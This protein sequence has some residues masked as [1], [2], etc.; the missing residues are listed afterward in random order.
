M[1]SD[2]VYVIG[3]MSGTSL[4]GLDIVYVKFDEKDLRNFKILSTETISYSNSW[5]EKLQKAI[6][7]PVDQIEKLDIEYGAFLGMETQK[8]IEKNKINSIDF[9]ASHGHTIFHQPDKGITLQI[10]NGQ[11]ISDHTD[12]KVVC[13]FRA[14]DVQYGGQGAPLVPIGDQLLFSDYDACVNLGGFAN[15]SF[16]KSGERIAFDICPVN[17]VLNFFSRKIGL[18][19]DDKGV[20]AS[21][22]QIDEKLLEKLN[23]LEFY[24]FVP[25]KSLGLEWVNQFVFPLFNFTENTIETF[26]RT[27]VEH[28]AL[29]IASVILPYNKVLFTGGGVYNDFL[30]S[31]INKILETE[32]IVIPS[33]EI[34]DYKESLIFALLGLLKLQGKVNCLSSVTGAKKNHSSGRI[35]NPNNSY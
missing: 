5:K 8:F 4:D 12:C 21:K 26:L 29:Q 9:I 6:Q 35:F 11:E 27:Y 1:D 31:R 2:F 10:G 33:T 15:I 14:Q 20:E 7:L 18:D 13:D 30:I 22:G 23:G 19:Y 16:E 17:I 32:I 24:K 28:V 25:P 34:I 3:L